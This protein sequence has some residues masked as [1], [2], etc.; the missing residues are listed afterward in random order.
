MVG[1]TDAPSSATL[2][3]DDLLTT[4]LSNY[5]AGGSLHDNIFKDSAF[6]AYLRMSDAV[7]KQSGGERIAMN[8][9]YAKNATVKSY[10]NYDTLDTTPQDGMTT[11]FYDW[12]EI[13]GT[14]SISRKE[15][16][17]NSGDSKIIGLL[18]SKVKQAEMSMREE[19]N[20]QLIQGTI[21]GTTF[22]PGN[23]AKDLYPLGYFFRKVNSTDPTTGGNVGNISG[24]TYSWWR[25][26]TAV[27][28]SGSL[29]TGNDF[30][31]SVTTFAGLKVA[32][33]RMYNTCSRGSGGSPDLCLMDQVTF[34]SYEN[35]LD[36]QKRYTNQAMA[37]MGFDT[38]KVKGATAVWDEL[39]PDVDTGDITNPLTTGTA[40]F[41]NTDFYKLVIDAETDMVVTP[42]V[43]PE[44]QT[45]R[46]A[47]IL[48]MGNAAV[49]NMRKHGVCYAISQSIVS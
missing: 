18:E 47:K 32:L 21:S 9:M 19:L 8:L 13:G 22:V 1:K 10:E 45:A 34:E 7:T 46:T 3:Y 42:F 29:D 14:I 37:D 31:L 25:H 16:R 17:Q 27:L 12:K 49:S 44:N 5:I 40:F 11:A 24:S 6:L 2:Y 39:V 33:H 38:V 43:S 23:S 26:H 4:T 35:A 20:R 15:E 28:D 48:F 41:I 30:A 36:T